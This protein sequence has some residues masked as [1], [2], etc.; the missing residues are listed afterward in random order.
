MRVHLRILMR[1]S[2]AGFRFPGSVIEETDEFIPLWNLILPTPMTP[3][4][5]GSM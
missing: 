5:T 4:W 3:L 1:K 2:D